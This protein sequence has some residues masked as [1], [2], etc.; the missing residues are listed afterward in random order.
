MKYLL[1]LLAFLFSFQLLFSQTP[2]TKKWEFETG[3]SINS[4]PAVGDDGTI[5]INSDKLYAIKPDGIKKWE[6][7]TGYFTNM[8]PSIDN[9]GIIY[10]SNDNL[11]A[12]YPD[13]TP[14]WKIDNCQ[15]PPAIA[16]DGILYSGSWNRHYAIKPDGTIKWEKNMN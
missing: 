5:Y 9:D 12:I 2:G 16:S 3:E 1:T 7:Q 11:F 13:G 14:K 10:I 8:S 4:S 6:S 15:Y